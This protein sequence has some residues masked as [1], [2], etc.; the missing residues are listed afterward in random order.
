MLPLALGALILAGCGE[1]PTEPTDPLDI[2]APSLAR[3][4]SGG[5][6]GSFTLGV[7]ARLD[8]VLPDRECHAVVGGGMDDFI[9]TDKNG[10]THVHL[11]GQEASLR[12]IIG[13]E[14][15]Y[16]G[17]AKA[18]VDLHYENGALLGTGTAQAQATVPDPNGPG[19]LKAFCSLRRTKGGVAWFAANVW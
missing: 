10:D 3:A 7:L 8:V 19:T 18:N 13:G 4:H 5:Q 6:G 9:R 11:K 12:V 17:P 1:G 16:Q 15:A 2:P 14:V